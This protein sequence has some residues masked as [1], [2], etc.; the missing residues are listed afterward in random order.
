MSVADRV[1]EQ[2]NRRNQIDQNKLLEQMKD[3]EAQIRTMRN[4]P[5]LLEPSITQAITAIHKA[6]AKLQNQITKAQ[7][8]IEN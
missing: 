3:L 2:N 6:S 8:E 1:N 5:M 4:E 7:K